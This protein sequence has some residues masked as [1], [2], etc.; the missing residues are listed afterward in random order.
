MEPP[1]GE[2]PSALQPAAPDAAEQALEQA[3]APA[4]APVEVIVPPD[5]L[6]WHLPDMEQERAAA[7]ER[8]EQ[9]RAAN[10]TAEVTFNTRVIERIDEVRRPSQINLTLADAIR[11]MLENSYAIQVQSYNPA[12][13]AT[14]IVEA[15]AAFDATFFTNVTKNHIDRPSGSELAATRTDILNVSGGVRKLLPTGMQTQLEY[16]T[17]RTDTNLAFQSINPEWFNTLAFTM[18]Q[19]LLRGFGIDINR[20]QIVITQN[21]RRISEHQFNQQVQASL[22][23]VEFQYWQLLQARRNVVI[24]ARLLAEFESI[25]E[26]LEARREFDVRPDQLNA[27]KARLENSRAD[28]IAVWQTLRDAE[29]ALINTINDPALDL[30]DEIEIIPIDFPSPQ[31]ITY[32]RLAE[33]QTA[34]E[35]RPEIHTQELQVANAKVVI[36]QARNAEL[37]RFDVTYST[38]FDGLST[39]AD[40][41]FDE[42]TTANF[43]EYFFGFEFEYPIGNRAARAASRRASLQLL[44]AESGLKQQI[45]QVIFEVNQALRQLTASYNQ[46]APSYASVEATEEE[47]RSIVARAE[48]RDINTLTTEL[49]ARERLAN[50]RQRLI[51][52]IVD[53]QIAIIDVELAKG[54]LLRHDNVAIDGLSTPLDGAP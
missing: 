14:Q 51:S 54:T 5:R 10:D 45:E 18:R 9:A 40:R 13:T 11:R 15:E 35:Y 52:T 47:I 21:N 7:L 36:G 46:I 4:E 22:R 49:S 50:A 44:Q 20:S 19:P 42:L 23:T 34:L 12:I 29:D 48:R 39:N 16:N 33:V 8:L 1:A 2:S 43:I 27:T 38:T 24:T 26:T 25:Y 28:F 17:T 31:L 3:E 30:A 32:D 37:P 53:S 41:A 6:L